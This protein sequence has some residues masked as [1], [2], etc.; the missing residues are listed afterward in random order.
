VE[1]RKES[2]AAKEQVGKEK[3]VFG[4]GRAKRKKN[5]NLGSRDHVGKEKSVLESRRAKRKEK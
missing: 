4:S 1:N 5:L 3:S 2:W